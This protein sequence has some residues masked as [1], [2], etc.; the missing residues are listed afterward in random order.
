[1]ATIPVVPVAGNTHQAT[2]FALLLEPRFARIFFDEYNEIEEQFS[3]IF[4]IK[5]SNRYVE[6]EFG[7]GGFTD[8]TARADNLDTVAY[9]KL[10]PGLERAYIHTA[11]TSGFI[12]ERELY[13]DEM[14]SQMDKFPRDLAR[15]GRAKV[16]KDAISILVNAFTEDAGGAGA[17]AIYDGKALCA[18]DHPLV[19]SDD[20]VDNLMS[21]PLTEA[22]LKTAMLKFR[23]MKGEAGNLIVMRP[24]KLIIPPNLEF[25]ARVILQSTL[26]PGG[27]NND[28]NVVKGAL[29]I[30]VM[31]YLGSPATGDSATDA[32]WFLQSDRHEMN[33]YWRIMPE[34]KAMEEFD[35]FTAKYRGYMRYSYGVSDFRGIVGSP[36]V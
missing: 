32:Y 1:M 29:Q 10:S 21:G 11:F 4:N 7:L 19:D 5:T 2:T 17:S 3:K 15:A 33:F 14:Y 34:F 22:N 35:N 24:S 12:V 18:V 23:A 20:E 31:D 27:P 28:I 25:A 36:G 26:L 6:R 13:D 30:V 9:Q 16:E 8:W